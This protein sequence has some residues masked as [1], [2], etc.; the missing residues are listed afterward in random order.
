MFDSALPVGM[1]EQARAAADYIEDR[2]E[3]VKA[4]G[5]DLATIDADRVVSYLNLHCQ[6]Q[7]LLGR[8]TSAFTTL[9][10][11]VSRRTPHVALSNTYMIGWEQKKTQ[12]MVAYRLGKDRLDRAVKRINLF[13][14]SC[15]I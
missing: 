8:L 6:W 5:D 10:E 12:P 4:V 2:R 9:R 1:A 14:F 13:W 15:S 3:L 7:A 11:S